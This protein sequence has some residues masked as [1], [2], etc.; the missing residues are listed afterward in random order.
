M[1]KLV[2]I[3]SNAL[4]HR[5]FHALPPMN[6]SQGVMTNAVYGFMSILMRM[7]KDL[8]PDY[9]A[10][11]FDLAAPTFRHE[12]FAEYKAHREKAPD[13]LYQQ[14]PI[15]KEMLG[16]LGIPV[17]EKAGFEADDLIGSLAEI[18]KKIDDLQTIIVTGDLDTLQLVE[19]DRVVVFT[20]R[21]GVTDTFIYNEREV[22]K[23]YNLQPSQLVDYRGLKGDPSD[24]IPG[25]PGIG[26]K[27]ASSL[28]KEFGSLDNLYEKLESKTK[29]KNDKKKGDLSDKLIQKL[30]DN[31]DQAYFS[32]KLSEISRNVS[33]DFDLKKVDWLNNMSKDGTEGV[34]KKYS[35]FSLIKRLPEIYT[36]DPI[37]E[38]PKEESAQLDL[39]SSIDKTLVEAITDRDAIKDILIGLRGQAFA[40]IIVD[41]YIIVANEND[42]KGIVLSLSMISRYDNL[43]EE[44]KILMA[45]EKIP[46]LTHDL[47]DQAKT[48]RRMGVH[49]EGTVFDSKLASY[50]INSD[51]KN[52]EL[53]R[54]YYAE[55]G[56]NLE[57]TAL[58]KIGAI[59]NLKN[60]MTRRM[61]SLG[62]INVFKDIELPLSP[63]LAELELI[64]VK[65]D[66]KAISELALEINKELS[67][68]EKEIYKQAGEE[69]NINSP[70]QL[71]HILFEVLKLK[72]KV[73]KTGK[74]SLSTAASELEKLDAEHPIIESIVRYRELQKLN[75]TYI[76]PFPGLI[77][78]STG[79]LYTTLNQTG[80][81]TG[82]LSSQ[83]PNLQNIPV[84]TEMGQKFRKSFVAD[85][86]YHLLS[87][88]YSQLELRVVA[89]ISKDQKMIDAFKR[90]EDIH[91]RTASEIFEIKP[92]D[93]KDSMR[94]DAKTLN[95]GVLYGMGQLG[96][97][98]ASGVTRERAKEFIHKYMEEFS[99]VARYIAQT[100]NR[101][102]SDGFVTT[103]FG[104][105][106]PI[107][108]IN[109]SMPQLVSQAERMAIN[110]PIQ[111]TAADM[112][113]IAMV[114][115]SDYLHHNYKEDDVRMLLQVHDELL[116]E[117]KEELLHEIEPKIKEI[118]E[119]V[120]EMS[121]PIV[122][123]SKFGKDWAD[124]QKIG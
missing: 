100:K 109:S 71:G 76:E 62:V 42:G 20:L 88:D 61:D 119:N 64:G 99:G 52:Y 39:Y 19:A 34:L 89:H 105:R 70:Q 25:V 96:F 21:K 92:E 110:M 115:V 1:K 54:V 45:D 30:L 66:T 60:P 40:F 123:D 58:A 72:G 87:C 111:G 56:E 44:L 107:T 9:I 85:D 122:V 18:S 3:D 80:T 90:G 106:R 48:L 51:L 12:E 13:E 27:T 95:F 83:E 8:R 31:K 63:V 98:R 65:I 43:K 68:L 49:V 36:V 69:F 10:A 17:F 47:K 57:N 101:A 118:M 29:K 82:R 84:R 112:I 59:L 77:N 116:F 75:T 81:T 11:T 28:I 120:Y 93:V 97:Q 14:I 121:V 24:N 73:R 4:V 41:D 53:D 33:I 50:L 35:L 78:K 114:R 102:H 16:Q 2:L 46:K 37:T 113:K 32:R 124:M 86:G 91:T 55:T 103:I 104:R 117:I 79:R 7:I 108:D 38:S 67:S 94:R 15:V 22:K 26:E 5:A 74:G 6:N 23:R